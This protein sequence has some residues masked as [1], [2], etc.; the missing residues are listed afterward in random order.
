MTYAS[1][2]PT[3][4][5][6]HEF[7]YKPVNRICCSQPM[8]ILRRLAR[9]MWGAITFVS[10]RLRGELVRVGAV[11]VCWG[12]LG[13]CHKVELHVLGSKR[14]G[15]IVPVE[16]CSVSRSLS[17]VQR[18]QG[19]RSLELTASSARRRSRCSRVLCSSQLH[20]TTRC[21]LSIITGRSLATM[22]EPAVVSF[23]TPTCIPSFPAR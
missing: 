23:S 21:G 17:C 15:I 4:G 1:A 11:S 19:V 3:A 6:K 8:R 18:V 9:G 2:P 14:A 10:M 22:V 20:R 16:S 12:G 13:V 7:V 5:R